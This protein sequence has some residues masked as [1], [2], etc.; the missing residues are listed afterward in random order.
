M[1]NKIKEVV[2]RVDIRESK[3]GNDRR[4]AIEEFD[5]L[6]KAELFCK[7]TTYTLSDSSRHINISGAVIAVEKLEGGFENY[8]TMFV[9]LN[10]VKV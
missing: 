10:G 2:F 5:T 7:A 9:Y 1:V 3:I 6:E 8:K 4:I